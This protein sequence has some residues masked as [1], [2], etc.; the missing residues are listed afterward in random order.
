M[1]LDEFQKAMR[2]ARYHYARSEEVLDKIRS[3]PR[4]DHTGCWCSWCRYL[5]S[6]YERLWDQ[7]DRYEKRVARELGRALDAAGWSDRRRRLVF[8]FSDA[9]CIGIKQE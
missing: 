6:K 1:A 5:K 3:G 2:R 7:Y 4:I 9:A 8:Q